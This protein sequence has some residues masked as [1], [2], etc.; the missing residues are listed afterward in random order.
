MSESSR[1]NLCGLAIEH[2]NSSVDY[3]P[4]NFMKSWRS[5]AFCFLQ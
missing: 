4:L 2:Q 5:P 3:P 1:L